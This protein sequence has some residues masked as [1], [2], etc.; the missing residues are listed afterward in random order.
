MKYPSLTVLGA[1]GWVGSALVNHLRS[2]GEIVHPITRSALN[3]WLAARE[4]AHVIYAIGLTADFRG[5]PHATVEAHVSLLSR[6]LQRD[7]LE[8][9]LL[10]SSTRVY[11]R[12]TNTREE[13]ALPC[14]SGDP[15]DLYNLSKLTGEALVLQ[16]QRPSFRVVRLSNVVGADQPCTTFLGQILQEACRGSVSIQ[17]SPLM[18]K[19]YID[20]NDVVRL[21]PLIARQGR[22]RLYNLASGENTSHRQVATLLE[23]RGVEVHFGNRDSN[24][25]LEQKPICTARL[26][27]EFTP[28]GSGLQAC[29]QLILGSTTPQH[30]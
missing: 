16:E 20:L 17:Q 25:D 18:A 19:D 21:L 6:V 2:E 14:L 28:A 15:S 30:N 12:S 8:S 23:Q 10:L 1:G 24:P 27:D 5:R 9:L 22:Q 4:P 13:A 3:D 7:A 26:Q 29:R 11:G